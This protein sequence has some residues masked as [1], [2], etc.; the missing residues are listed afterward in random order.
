MAEIT[1]QFPSERNIYLSSAGLFATAVLLTWYFVITMSGGMEMPGNWT[2]S[3][4]WMVMPGTTWVTSAI[5]FLFMW[6]AMMIAMMLPSALP[7]F[8][9]YRR[10]SKFRKH[11]NVGRA[12][13]YLGSAYF[14]IW[15]GFGFVAY[16]LGRA[17]AFTAMQY[18]VISIALPT[19]GGIALIVAGVYQLTPWKSACLKH[20]RD[21][22]TLLADYQDGNPINAGR[23]GLHHG[24]FCAGCCWALMVIQLVLGVMN[25]GLMILVASIIAF[26]KLLIPGLLIARF[27]GVAAIFA[28]VILVFHSFVN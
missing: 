17:I 20:C 25:I 9:L 12:L 6:E 4:M 26:E 21:P 14:L 13:W 7:M 11:K 3:M 8:L 23:L 28:G 1:A 27:T 16:I 18:S 5:T 10:S 24:L 2:M 15:L 19:L 22:L